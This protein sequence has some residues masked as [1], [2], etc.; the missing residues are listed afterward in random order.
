M[1][2]ITDITA[3]S[4]VVARMMP[5]SVRK[6]RSLLPRSDWMAPVTASQN[7]ACVL[8]QSYCARPNGLAHGPYL[9][10]AAAAAFIA[11]RAGTTPLSPH[12]PKVARPHGLRTLLPWGRSS[13]RPG[14]PT[15]ESAP[16][17]PHPPTE[18]MDGRSPWCRATCPDAVSAAPLPES[19]P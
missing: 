17:S 5:S 10:D 9:P 16:W 12:P 2:E 3:I 13:R 4:V 19:A 6:L 18:L 11:D 15:P 14:S 1:P 8:I 7:D